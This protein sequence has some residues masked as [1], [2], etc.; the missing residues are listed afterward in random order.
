[1]ISYFSTFIVGAIFLI[2]G[3]IKAFSSKEFITQNYRYR[4]LPFR[5]VPYI[6]V[7][8]IGL[9]S[10]LGVALILHEFP[11]WIIPTSIFLLVAL[12]IL[13]Y[14]STSTGRTEDCGCYG[15]V[16]II[17]PQQSL[18]LNLG[19]ILLLVIA[20]LNP[21]PN[22]QTETWQW[23]LT[24]VVMV[25]AIIL[26][27]HSQK[28][29]IFEF[30][31]LKEGNRWKKGWLKNSPYDLQRGSY[32]IV[33][34]SQTC[35]YC[36]RLVPFLNMMQTQKSL[37]QVLGILSISNDEIEA[38]KMEQR[39]RF[40]VISMDKLLFRYMADAF[41][42]AALI[43]NGQIVSKWIGEIPP[44]FLDKIKQSYEAAI[45]GKSS[46]V[47]QPEYAT[48]GTSQSSNIATFPESSITTPKKFSESNIF[49]RFK[50]KSIEI[51]RRDNL[52]GEEFYADYYAKSKPVII[53]NMINQWT[54]LSLWTPNY[55]K[56][57]YGETE[58]EIMANRNSDD[59][60]EINIE[61][62]KT[63]I[64]FG[65]YVDMVVN[66]GENNDYYMVANNR[67]L[68][69]T[70]LGRLL[71]DIVMPPE[72][73][74]QSKSSGN[75]FFWFGSAGTITPLHYDRSN[76]MMAQI[77]GRKKWQ[78]IP[79]IY[80]PFLYNNVG[81]FSEVDCENPDYNKHPLFEE[82]KIIEVV[83]EPGEIIFVPTGWWHQVKSL[84]I[85]VS[86]SFTNF[87]F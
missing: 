52:S 35:G 20:W 15:G 66:Q 48:V 58:V 2:S 86:L 12:T 70:Q 13:N 45:L 22:H 32:F 67:N 14:W 74:D 38:F 87:S 80:T 68:E 40:P 65:D 76:L 23:I 37:P 82:V 31:R 9:E 17:T 60:Y 28:Q 1:M 4:L 16:V 27:W 47:K 29:P 36:K 7:A 34:F 26:S 21:I 72:Y 8:F 3:L 59:K 57:H 49:Q 69:T 73:L 64:Q 51:D 19:Y 56:A 25:D 42:T 50:N 83:L 39:A 81:V 6:A 33:F 63:K 62:H 30:N 24:L 41:P 79:P 78:I 55:L 46:T 54:A 75:V 11:Q 61:N 85:S 18:L 77:Y 84:D 44:E 53:T 43:E 5:I 71:E 10:A